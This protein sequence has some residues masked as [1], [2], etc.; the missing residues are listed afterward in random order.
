MASV[1]NGGSLSDAGKGVDFFANLKTAGNFVPVA[2]TT[3]TVE[4]GTTPVVLNWDY[5]AI[6]FEKNLPTWKLFI[7]SDA[8]IAGY[9]DQA[10][11]KQAPHPAAA[12]L[13]E[14]FLYSDEGQNLFLAGGARPVR[15]DAMTKAG[16][17]DAAMAAKLP[18][19]T[20]PT[21][22]VTPDQASAAKDYL[23]AHWAKAIG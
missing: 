16:T 8:A 6:A 11:N 10:I 12:R 19:V 13:W 15:T 18:K 2:A 4:N 3:A 20:G 22:V 21:Q 14:E 23:V 9:Y 5:L 7:P 17:I 1:A